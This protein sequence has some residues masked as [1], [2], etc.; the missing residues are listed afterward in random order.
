MLHGLDAISRVVECKREL[1]SGWFRQKENGRY[2]YIER[3]YETKITYPFSWCNVH[4]GMDNVFSPWSRFYREIAKRSRY[5]T[6]K[7]RYDESPL[8]ADLP[9]QRNV[10]SIPEVGD[11]LFIL[12]GIR[13]IHLGWGQFMDKRGSARGDVP[14]WPL[15]FIIL[16]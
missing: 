10:E 8:L 2:Q 1:L 9:S 14:V 12:Q 7:G 5:G 15:R 4:K 16:F 11:H 6:T 13:A 3:P